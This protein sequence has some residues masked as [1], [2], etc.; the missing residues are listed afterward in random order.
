VKW[1]FSSLFFSGHDA[2]PHPF[3]LLPRHSRFCF[4]A[5]R[6]SWPLRH[7]RWLELRWR[8]LEWRRFVQRHSIRCSAHWES[9]LRP[10]RRTHFESRD[11]R[12][13]AVWLLVSTDE[14]RQWRESKLTLRRAGESLRWLQLTFLR[15]QILPGLLNNLAQDAVDALTSIPVFTSIAASKYVPFLGTSSRA[16]KAAC[17][18]SRG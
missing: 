2:R 12:C 3:R 18:R 16:R 15:L 14:P 5:S 6:S 13:I 4:P 8:E 11:L 9:S 17:R 7:Q 1:F 10:S